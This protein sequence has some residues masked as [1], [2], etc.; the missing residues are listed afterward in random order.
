[1]IKLSAEDKAAMG[2]QPSGPAVTWPGVHPGAY[3]TPGGRRHGRVS[4]NRAELGRGSVP[5]PAARA[6]CR[7]YGVPEAVLFAE[8]E[9]DRGG[10]PGPFLPCRGEADG[11][12]P[13]RAERLPGDGGRDRGAARTVVAEVVEMR[14][15]VELELLAGR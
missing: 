8:V 12:A 14:E 9:A 6:S 2:E 13:G 5:Q 3:P 11:P 7:I 15:F 4:D 1:M 10:G